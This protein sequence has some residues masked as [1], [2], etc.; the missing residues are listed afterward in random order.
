M[1]EKYLLGATVNNELVFGEFELRDRNGDK[2]FSAS[3]IQ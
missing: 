2:I 1:R 3:L